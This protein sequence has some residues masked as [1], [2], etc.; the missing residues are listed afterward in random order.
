M[1]IRELLSSQ[2]IALGA[3]SANKKDII[4]K[5]TVLMEA[6]GNLTDR[7]QYLKGVLKREAEGTTGIGEGVAIPHAKNAAVKKAGLAAMVL[8]QTVDFDSLDGEPVK[9]I[10]MIAAPDNGENEHL[11]ALSRLSTMLMDDEFRNQLI[12]A[13][14][15][16][17]FLAII[18]KKE[19]KLDEKASEKA[20]MSTSYKVL[21]IT[22]CPTGI[23]HTF[24]AAESLETKGKELGIPVK[25]ETQ[26]A[27]GA[28]N[29]LTAEEIKAADGIIIAADKNVNLA[30]FDGK[31]VLITKVA[32]GIHKPEELI[33]KIESGNVSI[34]HHDGQKEQK[35]PE[36]KES[37]GRKI[38]K[39]LMNG[40]SNMLPF[41][42]GGGILIA[43]AFL[44]DDYSIDP[45]NFGKNTP[46]AAYFKTIGEFSF[47]MMLPVLS[48]FIAMSIADRP[49]LAVGFVAGLVAKAG[50]TFANPAGGD[51]N[52][53]FL[54]ALFAGFVAGYVVLA[55]KKLTN[56]IPQSLNSIRPM[57][58]YP[59]A[60]ILIGAV[61]TT[62]INPFMGSINDAL[63]EVLNSMNGASRVL[64]GTICAGMQ[65]VDMGGPVNKT[66]YVFATSQLAEGNFEIMASVMAGGMV[67]PLAI[68]FCTTLF[69][70]RFTKKERESGLVNYLLG[71]SFISEG[72]IPFAA[73]DPLR[74]IPSC[75]VGSAVAGGLSMFFECTLRAPHG[76]VFVLPT[77]GHPMMYALSILIG[78]LIGCVI[79]GI[80]KK[81]LGG[82]R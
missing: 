19:Q 27:D 38:Y 52:A 61:M 15:T 51:V 45:S 59:V 31:K 37:L 32:D 9:L 30:R 54:G 76:G 11:E 25:V 46:I 66:S 56:K 78:S 36:V 43:I 23:A 79:L 26:G 55:L 70:N 28:K 18:D 53:G 12:Q 7:K 64:L 39:D 2:S 1:R 80:L 24:M 13:E 74:V 67:P 6:S 21:A 49:G 82:E 71:L 4:E 3:K 73:S 62:L 14:D 77:I 50:S 29:V 20:E 65:S 5:M 75:I 17:Q 35:Q 34:Y 72:A 47:G 68:A 10:F 40:V 16:D 41:V 42:I 44:L 63:T 22:A 8:K 58:I 69:K 48:G 33:Q 57:I 60:G 81:P